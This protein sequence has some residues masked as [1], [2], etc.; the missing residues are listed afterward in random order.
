MATLYTYDDTTRKEDVGNVI[1]MLDVTDTQLYSGLGRTTAYNTYHEYLKDATET[2]ADNAQTEGAS[3][4]SDTST[5]PTR[6]GNITQIFGKFPMVSGT[7]QT[8]RQYGMDKAMEYQ[9]VKKMSAMKN[10]IEL[11][12]MRGTTASGTGSASRR[13]AGAMASITTVATAHASGTTLTETIMN[14]AIE[15]SWDNGGVIDEIYVG[16]KLKRRISSFT[17]GATKNVDVDDKRLVNAVDVYESDFGITKIFKHR[18]IQ[19]SAD[20]TGN[21]VGIDSKRWKVS[22]LRT[23]FYEELAK[24]GDAVRGQ[25]LAELTLEALNESANFKASG[26]LISA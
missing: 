26:L 3:F 7:E 24:A 23:P 20:A 12:L 2:V 8:V 22:H 5:Q 4:S 6:A 9:K 21:I 13:L 18:H 14:D 11:A 16:A 10:D 17:G 19:V 15:A 1:D 25:I